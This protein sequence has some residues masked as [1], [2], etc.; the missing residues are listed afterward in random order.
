MD[1][2]E[3]PEDPRGSPDGTLHG[4]KHSDSISRSGRTV[5]WGVMP[6]LPLF[7]GVLLS[8]LLHLLSRLRGSP[9]I[10]ESLGLSLENPV[11]QPPTSPYPETKMTSQKVC[12]QPSCPQS[13]FP[14]RS[15]F[16]F[17]HPL[18]SVGE[19]PRALGTH[20]LSRSHSG[21][22][23]LSTD[24]KLTSSESSLTAHQPCDLGKSLHLSVPQFP[25]SE[26]DSNNNNNGIYLVRIERVNRYKEWCLVYSKCSGSISYY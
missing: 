6:G 9:R 10:P 11:S 7:L 21:A 20:P 24:P 19:I 5:G 2:V 16:L 23:A 25:Q 8:C 26:S 4:R 3:C 15:H 22:V 14:S 17:S 12:P 18:P 1:P 13:T